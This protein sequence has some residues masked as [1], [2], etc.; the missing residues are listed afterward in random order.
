MSESFDQL[1]NCVSISSTHTPAKDTACTC[2]ETKSVAVQLRHLQQQPGSPGRR[3]SGHGRHGR[4]PASKAGVPRAAST[5]N[6]GRATAG[7]AIKAP[8]HS[9]ARP[10]LRQIRRCRRRRCCRCQSSSIMYQS[11]DSLNAVPEL[12]PIGEPNM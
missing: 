6:D 3:G 11:E 1:I 2:K 10:Q 12:N 8:R 4:A 5:V 7:I 9:S